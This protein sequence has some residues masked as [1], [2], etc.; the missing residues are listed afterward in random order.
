VREIPRLEGDL[1]S[2]LLSRDRK[3]D[4]ERAAVL[5]AVVLAACQRA[6]A[7]GSR[8]PWLPHTMLGAAFRSGQLDAIEAVVDEVEQ[9]MHWN[10]ASTLTD[11]PDWIRHAPEHLQPDLDAVL[12]R[13][14]QAAG[15]P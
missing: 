3:G 13:L 6:R 4:A 15:A 11:A 8:D 5:E 10:L 12:A 9:G 7:R 2:L 14:R 1:P